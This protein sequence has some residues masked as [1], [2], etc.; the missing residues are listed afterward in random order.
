MRLLAVMAAQFTSSRK[1]IYRQF[2]TLFSSVCGHYHKLAAA[3][4]AEVDPKDP[5]AV[6]K[7]E[8]DAV[9]ALF[10]KFRSGQ[11]AQEEMII[12][13]DSTQ[14]VPPQVQ[15]Q[16]DKVD[17]SDAYVHLDG[18]DPESPSYQFFNSLNEFRISNRVEI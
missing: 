9:L 18:V 13:S 1:H 4:P 7:Q 15:E 16:M 8:C 3:A 11:F 2:D 17:A 12:I 10:Q 5:N 6:T 14:E